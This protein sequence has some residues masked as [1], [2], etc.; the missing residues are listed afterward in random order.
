MFVLKRASFP[1][2]VTPR[3]DPRPMLPLARSPPRIPALGTAARRSVAPPGPAA[4]RAEFFRRFPRF[5]PPP[6]PSP[7][8]AKALLDAAAPEN[9]AR[10]GYRARVAYLARIASQSAP[11]SATLGP[12]P[13][14]KSPLTGA[15]APA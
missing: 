7:A 9:A 10:P 15:L 2:F 12:K 14:P 1:E 8:A 3:M 4:V 5:V 11:A 6:G 13:P